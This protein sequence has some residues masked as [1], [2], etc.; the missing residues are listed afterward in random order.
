VQAAGTA[1]TH[2]PFVDNALGDLIRPNCIIVDKQTITVKTPIITGLA[3][4][5]IVS[6]TFI[7]P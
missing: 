2:G 4:Y 3:D 7:V 6:M 5:L 1:T